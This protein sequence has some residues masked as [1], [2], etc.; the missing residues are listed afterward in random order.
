VFVNTGIYDVEAAR[1]THN[2]A[3]LVTPAGDSSL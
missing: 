1:P 3:G 2:T